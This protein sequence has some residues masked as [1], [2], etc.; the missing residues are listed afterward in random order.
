MVHGDEPVE[1]GGQDTGPNPF[2]PLLTSLVNCTVVT[3]TAEARMNDIP[4]AGLEVEVRHKQNLMA[5]PE[6]PKQRQLRIT[7]LR[8]RLRVRGD[9]DQ[10]QLDRL[11][12]AAEHCPVSNTL[13][14]ALELS[15]TIEHVVD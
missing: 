4:L 10:E 12:W 9:L 15:T 14:Q 1:L 11:V 8:R 7:A 3:V 6:D 5:G 13:E 2:A